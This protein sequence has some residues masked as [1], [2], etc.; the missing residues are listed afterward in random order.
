MHE[1]IIIS[2]E[3]AKYLRPLAEWVIHKGNLGGEK[4][5][6]HLNRVFYSKDSV[7]KVVN[8]LAPRFRV[9]N[10]VSLESL[11]KERGDLICANLQNSSILEII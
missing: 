5:N 7:M 2:L 1:R 11:Q 4:A 9:F 10:L 6:Y 3:R 8:E